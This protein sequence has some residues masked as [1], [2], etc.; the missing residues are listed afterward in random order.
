MLYASTETF[1]VQSF[2]LLPTPP[3]TTGMGSVDMEGAQT[4]GHGR[5]VDEGRPS[6]LLVNGSAIP[7]LRKKQGCGR[8]SWRPS[9]AAGASFIH[10]CY[11][12]WAWYL[13]KAAAA[14]HTH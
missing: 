1:I 2:T 8:L 11:L 12:Y 10:Y 13:Q 14:V 5:T 3:L 7:G 6:K 9:L 4:K